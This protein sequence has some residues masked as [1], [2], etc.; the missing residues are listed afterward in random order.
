MPTLGKW[1]R[2][3]AYICVAWLCGV[4]WTSTAFA[5]GCDDIND[6]PIWKSNFDA[7]KAAYQAQEA[8]QTAYI[9]G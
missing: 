1:L 9:Q 2:Y 3:S 7:L 4:I 5:D 6:N 8:A